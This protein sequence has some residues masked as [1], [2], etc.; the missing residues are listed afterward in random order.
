MKTVKRILAVCLLIVA[1]LVVGYLVYTGSRLTD[2]QAII[3]Q[4]G[5]VL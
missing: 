1:V 4:V 2:G 5:G 3:S